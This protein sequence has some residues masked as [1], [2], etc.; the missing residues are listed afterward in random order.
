MGQKYRKIYKKR[1]SF[2][3]CVQIYGKGRRSEGFLRFGWEGERRL[4][5]LEDLLSKKNG[6]LII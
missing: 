5:P 3:R 2:L 1:A 4:L 6:S